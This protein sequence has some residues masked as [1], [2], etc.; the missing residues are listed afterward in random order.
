MHENFKIERPDMTLVGYHWEH[1]DPTHVVCLIH[2]IGEHDGRYERVAARFIEN[3]IA[4]VGMDMRGHGLSDGK[5]GHTAPR[6]NVLEDIDALLSCIRDLYPD[7]P[8][9]MYGHS[10]GGNI[11][12]DYRMRGTLSYVPAAYII[13]AP[14]VILCRSVPK[15]LYGVAT[16]AAKVMPQLKLDAGVDASVLGNPKLVDSY[17][18]DPLVHGSISLLCASEGFNIG[19]KLS[20]GRLEG[21]GLGAEKPTLLM[22]GT[23]D[24]ICSVEGSRKVATLDPSIEYVEWEG[25]FHEIHNGGAESDGS[26]VI[27]KSV[28]FI[29]SI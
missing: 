4:V 3:G 11:T 12:L 28:S 17:G 7:V 21:N 24:K 10:M 25:L 5:R 2:G 29:K 16:A 8:I 19:L 20:E 26:E 14:W 9:V 6:K 1:K 27:E 22:H 23:E 15:T 13:S 18:K